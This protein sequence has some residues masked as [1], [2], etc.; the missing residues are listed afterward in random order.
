[1]SRHICAFTEKLP[2]TNI[3][4][5]KANPV[6]FFLCNTLC[7]YVSNYIR[8][9]SLQNYEVAGYVRFQYDTWVLF[10]SYFWPA[11]KQKIIVNLLSSYRSLFALNYSEEYQMSFTLT[12]LFSAVSFHLKNAFII[13]CR[14]C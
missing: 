3:E 1:M 4:H 14:I 5:P 13:V 10:L 6:V 7:F 9:A 2:I 12:S 11:W 8:T